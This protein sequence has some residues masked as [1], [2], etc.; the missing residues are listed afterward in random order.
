M[1]RDF[2]VHIILHRY[3]SIYQKAFPPQDKSSGR[4]LLSIFRVLPSFSPAAIGSHGSTFTADIFADGTRISLHASIESCF[5]I[6]RFR[7]HHAAAIRRRCFPDG[8]AD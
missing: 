2:H 4:L 1:R 8:R 6:L 5:T 7:R 3:I